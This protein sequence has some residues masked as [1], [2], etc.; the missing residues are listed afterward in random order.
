M[1]ARTKIVVT[2]FFIL[3][4]LS[5][6]MFLLTVEARGEP[7]HEEI[8]PKYMTPAESLRVDEIGKFHKA[9]PPP[10]GPRMETSVSGSPSDAHQH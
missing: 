4:T 1:N 9:T 5:L 2:L 10:D 3:L 8:L 7:L 6:G